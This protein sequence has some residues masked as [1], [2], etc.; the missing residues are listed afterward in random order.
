[1]PSTPINTVVTY[2]GKLAKDLYFAPII[3]NIALTDQGLKMIED[4]QS[5]LYVFY[6]SKLDKV[7]K[8]NPGC[9]SSVTGTGTAITREL[10]QVT[11]LEIY[12]SQC[13]TVFD[14]TLYEAARK[15][16]KDI[17][18][19]TGT[20]IETL[21][22]DTIMPT[23]ERDFQRILWLADTS[24]VGDT[25]YSMLDG[26]FVKITAAV[27][28]G[29][30]ENVTTAAVTTPALAF[31]VLNRVYLNQ[32]LVMKAQPLNSKVFLV[33]QDV[34]EN[35]VQYLSTLGT[36]EISHTNLV[37]GIS[38]VKFMGIPVI[39]MPLWTDYLAA[40]FPSEDQSRV[41][42]LVKEEALIVGMDASSDTT[43]VE[44]WYEKKDKLNYTRVDYKLGTFI[45]HTE[46]LSVANFGNNSN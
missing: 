33:T 26:L 30:V 13:Y 32:K 35:Y 3:N 21:M 38:A 2:E 39:P 27:T 40:D 43:N 45:K 28:A 6:N 12:L 23:I 25:D 41:I 31:D 9:S 37:S 44:I 15:K 1:M 34:Y 20:E 18:D 5:R 10:I 22:R 8:A 29:D 7:T 11:D 19:L 17:A 24:N 14:Q 42:L 4:I 36:D 46:Y 16:G